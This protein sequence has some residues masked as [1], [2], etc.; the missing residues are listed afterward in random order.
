[1]RVPMRYLFTLLTL[2]VI[3]APVHSYGPPQPNFKGKTAAGVDSAAIQRET[4]QRGV[5]SGEA[6]GPDAKNRQLFSRRHS[7]YLAGID[8]KNLAKFEQMKR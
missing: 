7:L 1:M 8:M 5:E 3:L 6:L 2:A 4:P